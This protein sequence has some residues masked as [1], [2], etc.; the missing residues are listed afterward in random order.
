MLSEYSYSCGTR[1]CPTAVKGCLL[2]QGE[3]NKLS[4]LH[5]GENTEQVHSR[6]EVMQM[7]KL[8]YVINVQIKRDSAGT[9]AEWTGWFC[10]IKLKLT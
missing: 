10:L 1:T 8:C 9:V 6:V 5:A 2:Y 7:G 4:R 3:E